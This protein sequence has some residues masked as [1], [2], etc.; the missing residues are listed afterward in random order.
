MRQYKTDLRRN[1]ITTA[2]E[3]NTPQLLAPT[4]WWVLAS[5]SPTTPFQRRNSLITA[6]TQPS[7]AISKD[8]ILGASYD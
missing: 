7:P 5:L 1:A 8:T 3:V 2:A 4:S 6:D